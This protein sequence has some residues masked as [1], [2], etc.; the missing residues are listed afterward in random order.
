MGIDNKQLHLKALVGLSSMICSSFD[1]SE[2]RQR[3]IEAAM[4]LAGTEAGSLLLM[5]SASGELYFEVALG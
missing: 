5:D 2:I 1:T 3:T 4:S